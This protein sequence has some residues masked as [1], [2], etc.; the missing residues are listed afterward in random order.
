VVSGTEEI[1]DG[2]QG[3][4]KKTTAWSASSNGSCCEGDGQ[5]EACGA[6]VS[7]GRGQAARFPAIKLRRMGRGGV[8]VQ[9]KERGTK[10]EQWCTTLVTE[11]SSNDGRTAGL[12]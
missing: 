10:I 3:F 12:R 11:S 6:Q 7:F 8:R 5:L 9:G 4:T 2:V 1:V